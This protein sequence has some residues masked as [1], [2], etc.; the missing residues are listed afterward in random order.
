MKWKHLLKR[1]SWGE[2]GVGQ[3]HQWR[4]H[5]PSSCLPRSSTKLESRQRLGGLMK[6]CKCGVWGE[7]HQGSRT[8]KLNKPLRG[9]TER[10][11]MGAHTMLSLFLFPSLALQSLCLLSWTVVKEQFQ[12]QQ[13][14]PGQA[15]GIAPLRELVL[16]SSELRHFQLGS[17]I[18]N[19]NSF[20]WVVTKAKN[21]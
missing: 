3:R 18:P 19:P 13:I 9:L 4:G 10:S 16:A 1:G 2:G 8:T 12:I 5:F 17:G 21:C 20:P 7:S 6:G 11:L 14:W 15:A